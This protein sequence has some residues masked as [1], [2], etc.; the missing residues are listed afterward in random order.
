[1]LV[2]SVMPGSPATPVAPLAA[3]GHG[4]GTGT[5]R[6][7]DPAETTISPWANVFNRLNELQNLDPTALKAA[8]AK[9]AAAVQTAAGQTTGADRASLTH[10]GDALGHIAQTGDVAALKPAAQHHRHHTPA[11]SSGGTGALLNNLLQ[12]ID[13]VLGPNATPSTAGT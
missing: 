10:L 1:M 4:T 7:D 5:N 11:H 8:S 13:I 9:L 2:Q 3:M 6:T 12:Q